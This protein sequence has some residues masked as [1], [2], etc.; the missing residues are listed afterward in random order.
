MPRTFGNLSMHRKIFIIC[1]FACAWIAA[2][3]N[4]SWTPQTAPVCQAPGKPS[5]RF[6]G[7]RPVEC[8]ATY[9]FHN[10]SEWFQTQLTI[11]SEIFQN[12]QKITN[13]SCFTFYGSLAWK[14]GWRFTGRLTYWSSGWAPLGR[15]TAEKS[16]GHKISIGQLKVKVGEIWKLRRQSGSGTTTFTSFNASTRTNIRSKV[17]WK[18][19]LAQQKLFDKNSYFFFIFSKIMSNWISIPRT[20]CQC[21]LKYVR[22][23]YEQNIK[24]DTF[25]NAACND[26]G[27]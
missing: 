12:F 21:F 14:P 2:G 4:A 25:Q 5:T 27:V 15:Q 7:E 17:V 8:E 13:I 16:S 1:F 20:F 23:E 24:W 3:S 26:F 6:P 19:K 18:P 22:E 11:N 10:K 9:A